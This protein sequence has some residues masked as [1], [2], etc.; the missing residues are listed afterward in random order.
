MELNENVLQVLRNF[1]TI[2]QNILIKQGNEIRT[3]SEARNVLAKATV[4]VDFPRDFAVYDLGQFISVLSLVDKPN[5]EFEEKSVSIKDS[6]GLSAIKY[7]F[8]SPDTITTSEKDI[9]MPEAEVQF[10]LDEK[11]LAKLRSASSALGYKDLIITGS[12]NLINLSIT[13]NEN[14]TAN[15]F[16]IDVP[17][18]SQ[19]EDFKF[20]LNIEN[21]KIV[22]GDYDVNI[23]S[24][25]ISNFTNKAS[26]IQYWIALEK[27]ST[28]GG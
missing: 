3:I 14:S 8:A 16:N 25:F 19:S 12:N 27:T 26:N 11:T 23:S 20:I 10:I 7:F 24:K 15:S 22:Q 21:L 2:N 13:E 9:A 1:A 4:D 18:S 6:S 5:L 17:G 28:Y